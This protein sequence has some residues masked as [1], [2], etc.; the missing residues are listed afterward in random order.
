VQLE[1]QA[2]HSTVSF[3][4]TGFAIDHCKV[5]IVNRLDEKI[6]DSMV[7]HI[8]IAGENVT[9]GYYKNEKATKELYSKDGWLRT[10][11]LGFIKNG[12]L[13]IT[14]R[15]KNI[16][17][18]NGQNFYPQD[19]ERLVHSCGINQG[20]T[21]A[22]EVYNAQTNDRGIAVF[23]AYK[24]AMDSFADLAITVEDKIYEHL[25]LTTSE[26]IPV[27]S[28]PKTTSGKI[29][30]FSLVR[31]YEEGSFNSVNKQIRDFA[32]IKRLGASQNGSVRARVQALLKSIVKRD[33]DYDEDF[34]LAGIT[35]LQSQQLISRINGFFKVDIRV[36]DFFN[37]PTL[38]GL[39]NLISKNS[40][41]GLESK[42]CKTPTGEF[43]SILPAH[44]RAYFLD[45]FLQ[46]G[47]NIALSFEIEGVL[48]LPLL[49][50]CFRVLI[51]RHESLRTNF[52]MVDGTLM[53]HISLDAA[54]SFKVSVQDY[55][56]NGDC[57]AMAV[58]EIDSL[59]N[60]P[61]NIC[62]DLLFR[63]SLF[64]LTDFRYYISIVIHHLI[65][66]GWSLKVLLNELKHLYKN[67]LTA[68]PEPPAVSYHDY[69]DWKNERVEAR[70]AKN[71]EYW[72]NEFGG[73][74]PRLELLF[75]K[76]TYQVTD[77]TGENSS[78]VIPA[79][80]FN[81]L[82]IIAKRNHTTMFVVM[83]SALNVLFHKYSNQTDMVFGTDTFGRDNEDVEGVIGYCLNTFCI[84]SQ[85]DL[86]DTFDGLIGKISSKIKNALEHQLYPFEWLMKDLDIESDL[87]HSSIFDV[88]VLYQ[89][90]DDYKGL[91]GLSNSVNT[92]ELRTNSRTSLVDF[93]FEFREIEDRLVLYFNYNSGAIPFPMAA[94]LLGH[95]RNLIDQLINSSQ[96]PIFQYQLTT[97]D[98]TAQILNVFNQ[99]EKLQV[100]SITI[101]ES[102]ERAAAVHAEKPAIQTSLTIT[103]YGEL[104]SRS[105][106]VA[107]SIL[108]EIGNN[109][110]SI[111]IG[112]A[113]SRSEKLIVAMLAVWI[114]RCIMVPIDI[115]DKS[116]RNKHV[117]ESSHLDFLITERS[118]AKDFDKVCKKVL[119]IDDLLK[120]EVNFIQDQP[121]PML[122]DP[123]YIMYTSGSTGRPKG[124][125]VTHR[126]LAD[127]VNTFR[128][129][130]GLTQEDVVIHQGS[131]AFD[132]S[133][134]EI[135]PI[136]ST[137]GKLVMSDDGGGNIDGLVEAIDIFN[138]TILTTTPSVINEL[139][140]RMKPPATLRTL[141]S[142]GEKLP[143]KYVSNLIGTVDIFNTYGPT[144][145][146]ICATYH[147]VRSLDD[148]AC[149]GKP[150][151]NRKVYILDDAMNLSPIGIEGEIC[152]GGI[153]ICNGYID[154]PIATNRAFVKDPFQ[155]ENIIYKTGDMG[156]WLED[157]S[158]EFIGRRDHQVKVRG[159]RIE[160]REIE[161]ILISYEGVNDA[162][163][164]SRLLKNSGEELVAYITCSR[165]L[166]GYT[167]KEFLQLHLPHFMIP[168]RIVEVDLIPR[169]ANS[170]INYN[171]LDYHAIRALE[172]KNR[173]IAPRGKTEKY[174][175]AVWA[176]I[177]V[178]ETLSALDNFFFLGGD[179]I[180]ASKIISRVQEGF[181]I[182]LSLRDLYERPSIKD[183]ATLLNGK[184]SSKETKIPMVSQKK[185]YDLTSGQRRV[186]FIHN[187]EEQSISH[188]IGAA[189]DWE[190]KLDLN[191]FDKVV[192]ALIQRHETLRTAIVQYRNQ[193]RQ[194]V[195]RSKEISSP[196]TLIDI[197]TAA[198]VNEELEQQIRRSIRTPFDFSQPPLMRI[199]LLKKADTDFTIVLVI[200]HIISDGW[201]I[202][203]L[204]RELAR[205]YNA[206]LRGTKLSLPSITVQYKD[207]ATWDNR[208][209]GQEVAL[210]DKAYWLEQFKA[211]VPVLN[212]PTDYPRPTLKS[213]NGKVI[214][215][216]LPQICTSFLNEKAIERRTT[217]F[218][219]LVTVVHI[220]LCKYTN[221]DD[222]VI[223]VPVADRPSRDFESQVGFFLKLLALR[224]ILDG[225][226]TFVQMVDLVHKNV[227]NAL[228]HNAFQFEDLVE[229]L[230]IPRDITRSPL[231]DVMVNL[232]QGDIINAESGID[233]VVI[234]RRVIKAGVSK[235]D[236]TFNFWSTIRG[237]TVDIEYRED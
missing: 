40:L 70:K 18:I 50:K 149:I 230:L 112:I 198:N 122:H 69:V 216:S 125:Q 63:V 73:G 60:R 38:E 228:S 146:T 211:G 182:Q 145:S 71:R 174:L 160:P 9:K 35:S 68:L 91:E 15:E 16:I 48:D 176:E 148:A 200:H 113:L 163:V 101:I 5:R 80:V 220:L 10:G 8:Q 206:A 137:G 86:E 114:D 77:H 22:C 53:Q 136:L 208:Q 171:D 12:R 104:F 41:Q 82:R 4:E 14:G 195:Y 236:L 209:R 188:N 88:L 76:L 229:A 154:D 144:E 138:V 45:Q 218:T 92:R 167:I 99:P 189:I 151:A 7:G 175:A 199:F 24:G 181:G 207:F 103:S 119:V 36:K 162:V 140:A 186:W 33:V 226:L 169:H 221:E 106:L 128:R 110:Q 134:E 64:Q 28:I 185:H 51:K 214:S 105:R 102:I 219:V 66:D 165:L 74:V 23:I 232:N 52:R 152:L 54:I 97:E 32:R 147:Q 42:I 187:L 117:L 21:A 44:Q 205:L 57:E 215:F 197:R 20:K 213:G 132:L 143:G 39:S 127:Y 61:F 27:K 204:W 115:S 123:A 172:T 79:D 2:T 120:G 121:R 17:I 179:S 156:R 129:H 26:I 193:P 31:D 124:I 90:F 196:V 111:R 168:T 43:H 224:N 72:L 30:Y 46:Y 157:G 84:R 155:F 93:Q 141:I 212:L 108:E 223:G 6:P 67:G 142:G 164:T 65:S 25:G 139:N 116:F 118:L 59:A 180:K 55:T 159:Y 235:Y 183:F 231:F 170:K 194:K 203:I 225:S 135:F 201:S 178:M 37:H 153:G 107:Q 98:E 3:V 62:D 237:L 210:I 94:R 49:N 47:N 75:R 233:D 191:L 190:G 192:D 234:K 19:I 89:N 95:F 227:T 217:L 11:D 150:I 81:D 130:F 56:N 173:Y 13:V 58:C 202:D 109:S 34:H 100:G 161:S 131:I 78:L 166:D 87:R 177:L 126:A 29:K 184:N 158:I 1:R 85:F 96:K 83:V 133:L 222:I